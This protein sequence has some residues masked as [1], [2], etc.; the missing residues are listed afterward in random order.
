VLDSF[1]NF[2]V[3]VRDNSGGSAVIIIKDYF[4]GLQYPDFSGSIAV[5]SVYQY[6][7]IPRSF[8]IPFTDFPGV[9]FN[10]VTRVTLLFDR[11]DESGYKNISGAIAVD[12]LEFTR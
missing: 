7:S 4:N 8:R 9:N 10:Q 2:R 3:R 11:A 6:K 1:K 12:D 5:D